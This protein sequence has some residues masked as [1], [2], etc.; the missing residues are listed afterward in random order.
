MLTNNSNNE[1]AVLAPSSMSMSM[2]CLA[3]LIPLENPIPEVESIYANEGTKAHRLLESVL[4]AKSKDE[5]RKLFKECDDKEIAGHI[6]DLYKVIVRIRD[7]IGRDNIFTEIVEKRVTFS[8]NIFG[9]LDFAI[10]YVKNG[11][12][13][14]YLLD[15]KYGRGVPVTAEDNEQLKTYLTAV[16]KSYEWAAEEATI[17]VYQPRNFEEA[18][19]AL[20]Q[21]L[22]STKGIKE[23]DQ[24]LRKLE[25]KALKVINGNNKKPEEIPG[26]HCKFCKRKPIC[27]GFAKYATKDALS[28]IDEISLDSLTVSTALVKDGKKELRRFNVNELTDKQILNIVLMADTFRQFLKSVE[29]YA[30][31]RMTTA[32]PLRGLKV[33]AGRSMRKWIDNEKEVVKHLTKL[34]VNPYTEKLIGITEAEKQVKKGML[35]SVTIK[36]EGKPK[37][38]PKDDPRPAI[39]LVNPKDML[40]ELVDED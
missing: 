25:K 33:V 8:E 26:S 1:H 15:L 9:T 35:D 11:K 32:R 24:S 29:S 10:L 37:L 6:E 13:K 20:D 5:R 39:E 17:A 22:I 31:L 4:K 28:E 14:V 2:S 18:D 21:W 40:T 34:G 16:M 19:K 12:K 38:V 30:A 3:S 27:K 23:W 36:P 7:A